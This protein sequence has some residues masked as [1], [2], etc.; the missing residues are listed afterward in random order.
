MNMTSTGS[1]NC[2]KNG[3]AQLLISAALLCSTLLAC[4]D[5]FAGPPFV[6]DDPEPVEY[7]HFEINVDAE[8]TVRRDRADGALPAVEI[9]YGLANDLQISVKSALAFS[10]KAGEAHHYGIGDTEIGLK[11]RFITEAEEGIRPQIAFAPSVVF[12]T[13]NEIRGLGDGHTRIL[14]PLWA[15]KSFGPWTTFGGGG[16][17]LNRDSGGKNYWLA[18]WAVTRQITEKLQLGGEFFYT[19]SASAD[20]PSSLGFNIGGSYGLGKSDR[21][22][23]SAGRGLTNVN[24]TNQF[25]YYA[26]YQVDF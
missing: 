5:A 10:H 13:G 18:G 21:I 3:R 20:E 17:V 7:H 9:N 11:Y 26:G 1:K 15:Q 24:R 8:G 23:F 12:P 2:E 16:Y 6:T 4:G 19:G 25:S 22:L 14:L